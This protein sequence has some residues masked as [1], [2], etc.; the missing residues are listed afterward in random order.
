MVYKEFTLEANKVVPI[1]KFP[2]SFND[3]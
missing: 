2:Y 3:N 1:S